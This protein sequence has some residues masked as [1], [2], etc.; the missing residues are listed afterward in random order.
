MRHSTV[1]FHR[2]RLLFLLPACRVYSVP[3][4]DESKVKEILSHN[5][6]ELL[7]QI[8][9]LVS[10]SISELKRSSDANSAGQTSEIKRLKRDAPPSFNKKSNED[11]YNA[12]KCVLEAVEDASSLLERKDNQRQRS[13]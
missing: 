10:S 3:I 1:S 8:K 9:D 6:K 2:V 5:N 12:T 13:T 4:M 7:S 11:Q